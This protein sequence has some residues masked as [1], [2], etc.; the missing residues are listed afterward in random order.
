MKNLIVLLTLIALT[1]CSAI[2]SRSIINDLN[3]ASKMVDRVGIVCNAADL[4]GI[5]DADKCVNVVSKLQK[6]DLVAVY[7]TAECIDSHK[8]KVNVSTCIDA[9]K[10]WKKVAEK[11]KL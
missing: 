3:N 1:G 5:P 9:V 6:A 8:E 4:L 7:D 10:G 2:K 11:L